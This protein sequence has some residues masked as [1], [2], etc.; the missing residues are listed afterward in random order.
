MQT[1][2]E[3]NVKVDPEEMN[4]AVKQ[5]VEVAL[6]RMTEKKMKVEMQLEQANNTIKER[7]ARIAELENIIR[8]LVATQGGQVIN[9]QA[10][11]ATGQ[12]VAILSTNQMQHGIPVTMESIGAG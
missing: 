7:D 1:D 5:E 4:K 10:T 11:T 2:F 9:A 6:L 12:N 8:Q 3:S